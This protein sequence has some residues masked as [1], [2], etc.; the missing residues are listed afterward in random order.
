M[1]DSNFDVIIIGAGA[2]GGTTAALLAEAGLRVL[3]LERG[4]KVVW[5][6][7]SRD[8]LR[9]QRF[10]RYGHNAGPE[11]DG[12]PRVFVDPMGNE[13]VVRPFE[14]AYSNNAAAVGG[15]T[16]VYGAQAWRFMPQDFRM[17]S[18]YGVPS[19]SSLADWPISYQ[20][21]EPDYEKAEWQIGVSGD[22]AGSASPRRRDYP[23]PPLPDTIQRRMLREAAGQ[24][25]WSSL[26]PPMAI[27]STLYNGRPPCAKCGSCVGFA[28]PSN[29]KNGT[30]NTMIPRA[31]KTGVCTLI[32][33]AMAHRID[34]DDRGKVIG[35]TFFTSESGAP[36]RISARSRFVVVSC[37]AI[38]SARLLLNSAS[39]HH[40]R[41][42]GNESDHVGRHLQ[43]HY[44]P[45]ATGFFA[46]KTYDGDGPGVS[47]ATCQF[48]H[49]NPGVIGGAMLANEFVKLPIH[50]WHT[51]WPPN[52]PRWGLEAKHFMRDN[53]GRTIHIQGP[54]QEIPSPESRVTIDPKV[55]DRWDIPVVRLS[56]T[57]HP[58]TVRTALFMRDKA[59]QWMRSAGAVHIHSGGVGLYLSGGQH[60]AGTCRMGNDPKNSVTDSWGRVHAHDNLFVIDGSLHVTNG[61]FNPV[62]TIYALAFRC[63]QGMIQRL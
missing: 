19:G 51:S 11:I 7:V 14:G 2:A 50:F 6:N 12:N 24:L 52:V 62:L 32:S 5:P 26:C 18:T 49:G 15:G 58:E 54:V 20:D 39:S 37:G 44:Y 3:L 40:P 10:A 21:L 35:V 25:G 48:N 30:Q 42:L 8:H 38:E 63:A 13:R 4:K 46:E 53:Y 36:Q 56:G 27:N 28:C 45:G 57:A 61:G 33:E 31:L 60:Q 34:T 41:G 59:E 1:I 22:N 43:G 47:I 9:N 55:R 17:A 23:M 29:S 16:L